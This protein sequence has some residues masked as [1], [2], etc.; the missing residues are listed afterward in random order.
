EYQPGSRV[1]CGPRTRGSASPTFHSPTLGNAVKRTM[2]TATTT[3]RDRTALLRCLR[4]FAVG[5]VDCRL[6]ATRQLHGVV[7]GPEMH[8]EQARIVSEGVVVNR[9]DL[10]VMLSE[11]LRDLIDLAS[12]EDEVAGDRRLALAGRLKIERRVYAHR[13]Q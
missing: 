10:N 7:V 12:D 3:R 9:R 13:G 1:R 2:T 6:Q 11:G 4:L 5:Q 8:V